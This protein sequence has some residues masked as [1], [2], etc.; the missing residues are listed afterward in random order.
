MTTQ[1]LQPKAGTYQPKEK[2]YN[3]GKITGLPRCKVFDK[4]HGADFAIS[5]L[6]YRPVNPLYNGLSCKSPWFLHMIVDLC[7]MFQCKA[8]YFQKD[9]KESRG[10]RIE[11]SL[12]K[13]TGKHIIYQEKEEAA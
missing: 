11:H 5:A 3:S 1:T 8:A 9:W 2:C 13:R 12:A 4:F 6:N 7:M 10:A